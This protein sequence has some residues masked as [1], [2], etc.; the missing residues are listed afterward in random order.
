MSELLIPAARQY[1]H[2]DGS[3]LLC[4]YDKKIT[5]EIVHNLEDEISRLKKMIDNGLGWK[6][7]ENDIKPF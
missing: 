5:E 6:D 1:M 3:G 2:N 7:L 4:G